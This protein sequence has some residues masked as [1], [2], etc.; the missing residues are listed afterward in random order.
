MTF[1]ASWVM[2]GCGWLQAELCLSELLSLALTASPGRH[3][4]H[5]RPA[6]PSHSSLTSCYKSLQPAL[7]FS[8][9]AAHL[10][11]QEILK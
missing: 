10:F 1:A 2:D 7:A 11:H 4:H 3:R 8:T 5:L 9:V 6:S